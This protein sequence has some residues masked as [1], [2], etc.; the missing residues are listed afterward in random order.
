MK[1]S[2]VPMETWERLWTRVGKISAPQKGKTDSGK[3]RKE[4]PGGTPPGELEKETP[5]EEKKE[6]DVVREGREERTE[7]E[8][9]DPETSTCR[10]DPHKVPR[11]DTIQRPKKDTDQRH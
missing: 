7:D 5:Q 8:S 11:A 6:P 10:H 3:G 4:F 2:R 9:Q 1:G